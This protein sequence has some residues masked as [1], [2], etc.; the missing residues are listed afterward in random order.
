MLQGMGTALALPFLE[1]MVPAFSALAQ[2]QA[3]APLRFGAVYF[4]NGA[5]MASPLGYWMPKK[6]GALEIT[7]ILKPLEKYLDQVTVVGNLSRAGGKSVTDHAVSSAGWLSGAVAKQTEAEDISLG[8]TIDQVIAK[9]VGQDTPFPSLEFATEDFSGYVGGCVPGYSCTYMN[10]ISWAGETSP[11]PMEINPRVAFERM[12]GRA[13]DANQRLSRMRENRSILDSVAAEARSL[14]RRVGAQDRARLDEYLGTVREI[15]RRIEKTEARNSASVT[16]V[17]AP[18][19][20]PEAFEDHAALMFD[21]LA[22]AYQADLTR[23][24]TYMMAREASQRTYPALNIPETHH[25][26]SHHGNQPDKMALHAKI[27][28]HFATIFANFIEKL[29]NSPDGDGSVLDHSLIVFGGGMS[30]GQAHSAYPL[31]LAAVGGVSG[32]MKGGRFVVAKDWTS[33]AN[34]WLS[35]ASLY[36][37]PIEQFGESNGRVEI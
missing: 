7:P 26:V 35:V 34:F 30:D 16:A 23:V 29:R 37:S 24:F 28:T 31:P 11:L 32:R 36:D 10:T 2:T 3:K 17:T 12:F 14:Q 18:V 21:L 1:S 4:P 20:V 8:I 22:V 33:V 25:D 6:E 13:G 27:D 5:P 19:G 9:Q 15:E